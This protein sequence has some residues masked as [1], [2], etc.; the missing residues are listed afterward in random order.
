[1]SDVLFKALKSYFE[2]GGWSFEAVPE[3]SVLRMAFQGRNGEWAFFAQAREE[4]SQLVFYSRASIPIE[5]RRRMAVAEFLTRANYGIILGNFEI[6][7]R[8]GEIRYKTSVDIEGVE[9]TPTLIHN[10]VGTNVRMMDRYLPGIF[11]VAQ[12]GKDPLEALAEIE[13][14]RG[15]PGEA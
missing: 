9:L 7:L 10:L 2:E 6:D 1:M 11:A 4:Q 8:D 14:P 3:R 12:E 15:P 13:R 5:E